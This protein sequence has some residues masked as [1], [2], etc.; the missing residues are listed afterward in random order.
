MRPAYAFVTSKDTSDAMVVKM[1]DMLKNAN[2]TELEK[3]GMVSSN[4]DKLEEY[5]GTVEEYVK[6]YSDY[7]NALADKGISPTVPTTV[8]TTVPSAA[9]SNLVSFALQVIAIFAFVFLV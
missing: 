7:Y 2:L 5:S 9:P 3:Y 8:P 6:P 1:Q 4:I